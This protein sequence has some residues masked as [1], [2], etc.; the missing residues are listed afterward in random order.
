[1]ITVGLLGNDIYEDMYPLTARNVYKLDEDYNIYFLF[2]YRGIRVR[3]DYK[4]KNMWYGKQFKEIV[5]ERVDG[6]YI[7]SSYA[8]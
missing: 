7:I 3:M 1:M 4:Q 8:L 2:G 6:M 5:L